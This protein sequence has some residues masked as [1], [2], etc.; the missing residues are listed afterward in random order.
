MN[1]RT[2]MAAKNV[3]WAYA[4][5]IA[6]TVIKF[7]VRLFFIRKLGETLLGINGLYSSV[8]GVL[9]LTELGIGSAM[10][11]SLYKPVAEDDREKIKTLMLFYKQAY[12]IIA[13]VIAV[14]GLALIP[15]LK[16]LIKGAEGV[17]HLV[18][19][20]LL[21]LFN[22]VSS[23]FVSYK[24]GLVHA[25]QKNYLI[26]N[27][28]TVSGIVTGVLQILGLLLWD[29]FL[30]YLLIQIIVQVFEKIYA[31]YYVDSIY[32]YLKEKD[33]RPIEKEDKKKLF[34][35]VTA[36]VIHKFGDVA[37]NQTDNILIS[38]FIS[39]AAT[40][41]ISNYNLV[42]STVDSF[43]AILFG[44]ITGSLGNLCALESKE[45]QYSVFRIYDFLSFWFYGFVAIAYAALIQPFTSLMWGE[46]F[47]VGNSVILL[48]IINTYIVGQRIPLN[49]M[50]VARGIFAADK[51]LAL[52][53]A[54]TNLVSSIVFVKIFGLIGIY[55]G[56]ILSGLVP[57]VLRPLLVYRDMFDR[58]V[59][60]YFSYYMMHLLIIGAVGTVTCLATHFIMKSLTIWTFIAA[61]FVTALLPNGLLFLLMRKTDEFIYLKNAGLQLLKK[62]VNK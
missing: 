33:V 16:Y 30:I 34:H 9:A 43:L 13:I 25:E 12:R 18:L 19:Y 50:K 22:T 26:N 49:N 60:D 27:I 45:K 2:E 38:S 8:L 39:V 48:I 54:L 28:H 37:V 52:I 20:Y 47:V 35:N 62:R 4:N 40:G 29:S 51:Y 15:F 31:Y 3:V 32:P 7:V 1:S 61:M 58:S 41:L 11:Y 6:T 24:Y 55:M 53:Q 46:R 56:T 42:I 57:T 10:N 21:F 36:L 23:Y 44:N 14:L 5:T 17:D 59:W